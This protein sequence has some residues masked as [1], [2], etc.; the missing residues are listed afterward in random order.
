MRNMSLPSKYHH[1]F[2][3]N[4]CQIINCLPFPTLIP[5]KRILRKS[6]KIMLQIPCSLNWELLDIKSRKCHVFWIIRNARWYVIRY[7][8]KV[9]QKLVKRVVVMPLKGILST[10]QVIEILVKAKT[11]Y[12]KVQWKSLMR[13]WSGKAF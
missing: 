1:H 2:S 11:V 7:L 13:I 3:I 12:R 10:N 9:V 4:L 6:N 8:R 5:K